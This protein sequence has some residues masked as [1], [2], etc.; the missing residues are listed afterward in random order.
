MGR[1]G[2]A[3]EKET[4]LWEGGLATP[5]E[6]ELILIPLE[7]YSSPSVGGNVAQ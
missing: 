7:P 6:L 3:V 5:H 4:S 1:A 2:G